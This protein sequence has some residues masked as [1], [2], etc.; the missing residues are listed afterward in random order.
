ME[1]LPGESAVAIDELPSDA[2]AQDAIEI[3]N[4]V[5]HESVAAVMA[6]DDLPIRSVLRGYGTDLPPRPSSGPVSAAMRRDRS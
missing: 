3:I 5:H 2:D 1:A 6:Q 4:E